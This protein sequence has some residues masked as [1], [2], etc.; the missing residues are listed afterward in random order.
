MRCR[1][2]ALHWQLPPRFGSGVLLRPMRARLTC[3]AERFI[4]RV[5]PSGPWDVSVPLFDTAQIHAEEAALYA[6]HESA[7]V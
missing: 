3:S 7:G 5:E 2:D 1:P 4:I 6:L